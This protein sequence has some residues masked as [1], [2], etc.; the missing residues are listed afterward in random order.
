V[1]EAPV[2]LDVSDATQ[3]I[4]SLRQTLVHMVLIFD[5]Y[6]HFHGIVTPMDVLEGITGA[7]RDEEVDEPAWVERPDG[8][9]LIAGWMAVDEFA[10]VVGVPLPS[11][12]DYDTVAG[13][14]LDRLGRLPGLGE[15]LDYAGF[16]LEVIDLDGMR[17][18]KLLVSKLG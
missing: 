16:R 9:F 6:G 12:R 13:L 3:V 18:D 14:M 5:E 1:R 11:E 7:F 17:I 2:L 8:S 4:E 10:E 15:R